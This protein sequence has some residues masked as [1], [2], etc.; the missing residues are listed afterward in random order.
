MAIDE[1]FL[2]YYLQVK[3]DADRFKK[4]ENELRV[5]LVNE[6]FPGA[7][8]GTHKNDIGFYH[9]KASIPLNHKVDES[10]LEIAWPSLSED[11]KA[12]FKTEHT[13]LTS[14]IKKLESEEEV[15]HVQMLFTSKPGMPA[16]TISAYDPEED[17]MDEL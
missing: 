14:K 13:V 11:Q 5:K 10:M 2:E 6:L 4:L 15:E 17:V 7:T 12:C 3:D 16:L 9:V 1:N 8:K